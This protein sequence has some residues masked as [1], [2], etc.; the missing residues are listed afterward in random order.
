LSLDIF[1]RIVAYCWVKLAV[2]VERLNYFILHGNKLLLMY[3]CEIKG[4]INERFIIEP[5]IFLEVSKLYSYR[6]FARIEK[7]SESPV[8]FFFKLE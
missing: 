5:A 6:Y 3:F 7:A 8:S 4:H 2:R 1:R